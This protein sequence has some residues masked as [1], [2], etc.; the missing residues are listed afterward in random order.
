MAETFKVLG[1]SYPTGGVLTDLYTVPSATSAVISSLTIC[2]QG[3]NTATFRVSIVVA[4]AA[5]E[6]KQYLVYDTPLLS[7]G[8]MSIIIGETLAATDVIRVQSDTGNLSFNLFGTEI[9]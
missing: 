6:A 8:T 5:D 7:K 2:N 4:G 3:N 1:Q 9:T